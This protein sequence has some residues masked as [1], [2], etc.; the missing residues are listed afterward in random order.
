M[1]TFGGDDVR[2][3]L[4]DLVRT[5]ELQRETATIQSVLVQ[6][7]LE[8]LRTGA[9]R[10]RQRPPSVAHVSR[11][12]RPLNVVHRTWRGFVDSM[13]MLE[14]RARQ[15]HLKPT[16]KAVC[17]LGPDSVKTITRTMALYGLHPDDWPPSRWK[18]DR[19]QL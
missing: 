14:A 3:I 4:A 9:L 2:Q 1:S 13:Q 10:Q 7:E 16:K 5:A 15:E 8:L 18:I 11:P 17:G 12:Y 19:G 6:Q